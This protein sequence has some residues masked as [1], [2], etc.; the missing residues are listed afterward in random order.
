MRGRA[1]Q[2][3]RE[4]GV[5]QRDRGGRAGGGRDQVE[6]RGAGPWPRGRSSFSARRWTARATAA[7]PGQQ[8][9]RASSTGVPARPLRARQPP[10]IAER[11]VTLTRRDWDHDRRHAA[12]PDFRARPAEAF[13]EKHGG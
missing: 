2:P 4:F 5:E 6:E 10:A 11:L 12:R 1:D 8:K 9:A 13:L 7:S 3:A